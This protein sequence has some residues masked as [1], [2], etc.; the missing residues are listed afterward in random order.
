AAEPPHLCH[1]LVNDNGRERAALF[2]S[3]P[4]TGANIQAI[5]EATRFS[6]SATDNGPWRRNG[7]LLVPPISDPAAR[8]NAL[9]ASHSSGASTVSKNLTSPA[10]NRAM[11]IPSR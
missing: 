8:N 1:F 2:H 11:G 5:F 9:C 10:A 4:E 6:R 3:P 7:R